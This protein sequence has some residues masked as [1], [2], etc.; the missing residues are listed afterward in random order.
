MDITDQT[1]RARGRTVPATPA[2]VPAEADDARAL[3]KGMRAELVRDDGSIR[4]SYLRIRRANGRRHLEAQ[5][6]WRWGDKSDARELVRSLIDR[7][8]GERLTPAAKTALNE[9]LQTYLARSGNRLGTQSFVKLVDTLEG[10]SGPAHDRYA[11]TPRSRLRLEPVAR[12]ALEDIAPAAQGQG[13]QGPFGA[14]Q[15]KLF[16]AAQA[17]LTALKA[18]LDTTATDQKKTYTAQLFR[19]LLT[20][21]KLSPPD[22]IRS[23]RAP[24]QHVVGDADGSLCRVLI[25][26]MAT[27]H[28]SLTPSGIQ[29]LASL[30]HDETASMFEADRVAYQSNAAVAQR[31]EALMTEIRV[32]PSAD[33]RRLVFMGDLLHDRLSNNKQALGQLIERLS[34]S[35]TQRA[36]G[37]PGVVFILGNH[38]VFEE[39][40]GAVLQNSDEPAYRDYRE[41]NGFFAARDLTAA[42]STHL[43]QQCFTRAWFDADLGVF[44]SHNG[45]IRGPNL[46][47]YLTGVGQ[48]Q[49]DSPTTLAS[50]MNEAPLARLAQVSFQ[51]P[52]GEVVDQA[53]FTSFRPDEQMISENGLGSVTRDG[54]PR[55]VFQVHG[56]NGEAGNTGRSIHLNARDE[57]SRFMPI[58]AVL[59]AA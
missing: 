50:R 37:S 24:V 34:G 1:I 48:F 56:H 13:A 59:N 32:H 5:S 58:C 51:Y 20:P 33:G 35:E 40:Q 26:A 7:A 11:L 46:G 6:R 2:G 17:Q 18:E 36:D 42:Q 22:L 47:E 45:V 14:G 12:L 44:Y 39:V 49:A 30:M 10:I 25:S 16:G 53:T 52:K 57:N 29:Q 3:L 21:P 4:P 19:H 54:Q 41:Q 9:A 23:V 31:F 38:D 28:L 55:P 8:Y 15:A 27:G 43:S